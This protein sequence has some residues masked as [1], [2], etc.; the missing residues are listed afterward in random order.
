MTDW[1]S[2]MYVL[3]RAVEGTRHLRSSTKPQWV[4]ARRR[5]GESGISA[6]DAV[7]AEWQAEGEHLMCG[8]IVGRDDRVFNFCVVHDHDAKGGPLAKG[9]GWISAWNEIPEEKI[10]VICTGHP[11]AWAVDRIV[12][13]MVF[14][15]EGGGGAKGSHPGED[16]DS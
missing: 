13:R 5:L 9:L 6:Q 2:K 11:N 7:L 4:D 1:A 15:R 3:E 14:D 8:S 16:Q 10:G 12:A